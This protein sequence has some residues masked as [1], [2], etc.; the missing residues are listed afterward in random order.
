MGQEKRLRF[1]YTDQYRWNIESMPDDYCRPSAACT[2]FFVGKG[3][4]ERWEREGLL[5]PVYSKW[6]WRVVKL[7]HRKNLLEL[8]NELDRQNKIRKMVE[9]L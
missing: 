7:Y 3:I 5:F 1:Q 6:A 8:V 9:S 4:L 2:A